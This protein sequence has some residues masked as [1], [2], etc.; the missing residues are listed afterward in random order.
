M[1]S[2]S[3]A[4]RDF[5]VNS[6]VWL[7]SGVGLIIGIGATLL[8]VLLLR[9]IALSTNLFYYHRFSLAFVS[10]AGSSLGHW[11][12]IIPVMGGLIVGLMARFGSDKIR[13]HGIPEA[14][15]AILLHRARIDPKIAIL[16]PIS[17][18]IAIGSG[19]PFGAEG[20]I[21]MTGGAFGS[22]VAQWI[23][24]ADVER[25]TLLVAGAAAGMSA[26]FATPVAAILLAVAL[27]LFELR[28]RSL[29]PVAMPS[30][31]AGILRVSW[32]GAGP[33]FHMPDAPLG[34]PHRIL[35]AIGALL[36]GALL[37][38]VA[39]GMSRLMYA[40]ED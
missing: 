33:L 18:A 32:L 9:L 12:V 23:R 5:T 34:G 39:A 11:M 1:E 17:A 31:T 10:P 29:V 35:F 38:L 7:L 28:P 2:E 40:F 6:R 20:P 8:A 26:T 30:A 19:G 27:L 3:S 14:I 22:L 4:L 24:L 36:L 16:K 37:G 21:I 25:T 15:E 13:G